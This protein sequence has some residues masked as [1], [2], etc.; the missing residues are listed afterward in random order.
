MCHFLEDYL[1]HEQAKDVKKAADLVSR[2]R[3][4]ADVDFEGRSVPHWWPGTLRVW[5]AP[6]GD[7]VTRGAA[8]YWHIP[9]TTRSTPA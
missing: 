2:A 9:C 3:R 4:C 1:L 5:H 8:A 6:N 7:T